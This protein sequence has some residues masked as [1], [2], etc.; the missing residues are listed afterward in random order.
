MIR[1]RHYSMLLVLSCHLLSLYLP[2]VEAGD[3][4][5][6]SRKSANIVQ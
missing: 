2:S 4:P 6:V 3:V 5:G 1:I